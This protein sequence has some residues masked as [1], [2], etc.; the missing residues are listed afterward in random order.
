ME[1]ALDFLRKRLDGLNRHSV[2]IAERIGE[3]RAEI[4]EL[5]KDENKQA[6]LISEIEAALKVLEASQ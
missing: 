4:D 1:Q 2:Y 3:K 5:T 6:S